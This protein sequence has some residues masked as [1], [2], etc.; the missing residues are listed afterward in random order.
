[1]AGRSARS[2]TARDQPTSPP[3][4]NPAIT[5]RSSTPTQPRRRTRSASVELGGI[6]SELESDTRTR[7]TVR[8]A[9][10][11]DVESNSSAGSATR[12]PGTHAHRTTADTG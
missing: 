11:E 10:V 3:H 4:T 12:R 1:M 8:E 2:T 7:N 5:R 9:G 6:D